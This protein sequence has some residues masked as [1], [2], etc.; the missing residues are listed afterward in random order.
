[1]KDFAFIGCIVAAAL[2]V[3]PSLIDGVAGLSPE[4]RRLR[5]EVQELKSYQQGVRDSN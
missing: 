4:T 2:I 5:L 3:A 1:M